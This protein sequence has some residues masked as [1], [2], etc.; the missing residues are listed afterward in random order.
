MVFLHMWKLWQAVSNYISRDEL[1]FL[2]FLPPC[3]EFSSHHQYL[4]SSSSTMGRTPGSCC[5]IYTGML[6]GYSCVQSLSFCGFLCA[7]ALSYPERTVH[8]S[9]PLLLLS[10]VLLA[11]LWNEPW[12]LKQGI[13]A[14]ILFRAT[15]TI[16]SSFFHV[17]CLWV[18][19]LT[20]IHFK[21]H[22]S[23]LMFLRE[24]SMGLPPF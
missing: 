18:S 3:P 9:L 24:V 16:V 11:P 10:I 5:P 8:R 21:K 7:T 4:A 19:E 12:A 15:H 1:E 22:F 13:D 2:I 6:F 23:N 14:D 17:D 20:S